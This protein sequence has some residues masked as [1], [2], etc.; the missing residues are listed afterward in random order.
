MDIKN[1]KIIAYDN[2]LEFDRLW[3]GL[4]AKD[5]SITL[6][7]TRRGMVV[8]TWKSCMVDMCCLIIKLRSDVQHEAM[9]D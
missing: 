4:Q 7:V 9:Y 2:L 3:I 1:K 5:F 8:V 6:G